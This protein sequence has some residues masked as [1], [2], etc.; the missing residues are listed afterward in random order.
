MQRGT[1]SRSKRGGRE[2]RFDEKGEDSARFRGSTRPSKVDRKRGVARHGAF[3]R[4][5]SA[6]DDE[7]N[8]HPTLTRLLPDS[9]SHFYRLLRFFH[10]TDP[11]FDLFV[12]SISLL[13]FL[14]PFLS[15]FLILL[16]LLFASYSPLTTR[17]DVIRCSSSIVALAI[18]RFLL[19]LFILYSL[20]VI[21][22]EQKKIKREG[23]R[24]RERRFIYE[25]RSRLLDRAC[26]V[27][28]DE[29]RTVKLYE[30]RSENYPKR[31]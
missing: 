20:S 18:V 31:R 23:G 7:P 16:S 17:Q 15:I 5:V 1:R 9:Y 28:I 6:I 11:L 21:F 2:A 19:K 8:S 3:F 13:P 27:K 24:Y 22:I 25:L 30:M 29:F 12:L 26:E 4:L 14:L 10:V